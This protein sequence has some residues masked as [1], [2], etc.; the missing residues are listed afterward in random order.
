VKWI[1][2]VLPALYVISLVLALSDIFY[3]ETRLMSV[4]SLFLVG[5][6]FLWIC[7]DEGMYLGLAADWIYAALNFA[8]WFAVS[9]ALEGL[10]RLLFR[11]RGRGQ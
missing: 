6:L 9:R 8:F 4:P 10:V 11:L 1:R 5:A 3:N 2:W 7:P